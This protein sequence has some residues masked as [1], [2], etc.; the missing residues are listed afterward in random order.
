MFICC[1]ALYLLVGAAAVLACGSESSPHRSLSGPLS[2]KSVDEYAAWCGNLDKR[3]AASSNFLSYL[4]GEHARVRPPSELDQF[5]RSR[6]QATERLWEQA[7]KMDPKYRIQYSIFFHDEADL[8]ALSPS[9]RLKLERSGCIGSS[10][11]KPDPS[12]VATPTERK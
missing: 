7:E 8:S 5:H 9:T 3:A 2:R 4:T 6:Q 10:I 1:L 11:G 12:G